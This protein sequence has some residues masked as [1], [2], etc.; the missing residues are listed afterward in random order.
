[1]IAKAN[2]PTIDQLSIMEWAKQVKI[3]DGVLIDE[4]RVNLAFEAANFVVEEKPGY[5]YPDIALCRYQ[6][7]EIILRL[8]K[9]KYIT[10]D[11]QTDKVSEAFEMIITQCIIP[12]DK[13]DPWTGFRVEELWTLPVNDLLEPNKDALL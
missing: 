6:F 9:D 8:G 10:F 1:M 12:N 7:L 4:K 11:K 2:F 13:S 3:Y 5:N